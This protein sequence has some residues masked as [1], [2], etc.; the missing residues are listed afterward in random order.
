VA[1]DEVDQALA[2]VIGD[3]KIPTPD[4]SSGLYGS[5]PTSDLV[6]DAAD[7][8][9][10]QEEIDIERESRGLAPLTNPAT[11]EISTRVSEAADPRAQTITRLRNEISDLEQ[12]IA[13]RTRRRQD[14]TVQYAEL[15]RLEAQLSTLQ[16][17]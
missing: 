17:G 7:D 1:R 6:Y 9:Q 16:N 3:D 2:E 14:T 5:T 15:A 13:G 8:E 10:V 4:F 11:G 12:I